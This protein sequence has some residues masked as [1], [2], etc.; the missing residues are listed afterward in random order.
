MRKL[1]VLVTLAAAAFLYEDT[2]Q[3]CGCFTPPDPTVPVVQ[4]GERI[5]FSMEAGQVEA[6]IQIQYQGDAAEFGWLLPVPTEPTLELGTDELFT[7]LINTT[8]P[9]YRLDRLYEGVNCPF[10]PTFPPPFA[11]DSDSAG[12]VEDGGGIVVTQDSVGPYDYA[13]LR[14]D[15]KQ[16]MLDWLAANRYF[17]PVGT[18]NVVD[19]Y[20]RPGA[21]FLALKLRS[22]QALGDLQPVVVRY[23]SD[24]PMIPIVLTSAAANPNMGVM[25]WVLGDSR[26][27]PRNYYHTIINDAAIDWINAGQN[28]VDVLT[29][30]VDEAPDHRSFVTEYAASSSPMVDLLDY[31]GRFGNLNELRQI[32]DAAEYLSYLYSYGYAT[33]QNAAPFFGPVFGSQML[34]ILRRELPMPSKLAAAGIT[35][36][37]YYLSFSYYT[38]VFAAMYPKLFWDLDTEFDPAQMTADI[39][40]RVVAPT[41]QAGAMFRNHPYLTRLF[42]TLSPEE[43]TQ[44]PVFSFNPDLVDVPNVHTGTLTF[45][46]GVSGEYDDIAIVPA[47]LVTESGWSLSLGDG[48]GAN[49]WI[50]TQMPAS[51]RTEVLREEGAPR[52]VTDNSQ[53]IAAVVNGGD[54]AGGCSVGVGAGRAWLGALLALGLCL[55]P[56]IAR[57]RR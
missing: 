54:S 6:H 31:Q 47:R 49:P 37:D 48:T 56:I 24:L 25:V 35:E 16:P 17:V 11:S 12:G 46:C 28:Y 39:E 51:L 45:H 3:A 14:A 43:M 15:S 1:L 52:V 18:E 40:E 57:R 5:I 27:I 41:L 20:I 53:S 42:T 32:T 23:Q 19:P 10:D 21:F 26:A 36:N 30:A 50:T 34:G 33:F 29:R 55:I 38:T 2:A 7:Q 13:V 44:D 9:K 4:A 8:Q 22:G